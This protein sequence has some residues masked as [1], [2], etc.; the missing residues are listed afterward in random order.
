MRSSFTR[1]RRRGRSVVGRGVSRECSE[2]SPVGCSRSV[3]SG[4]IVSV[5]MFVVSYPPPPHSPPRHHRRLPGRGLTYRIA[6]AHCTP[7]GTMRLVA[8]LIV[9]PTVTQDLPTATSAQVCSS[10]SH[11]SN[12]PIW[13]AHS[14]GAS[15]DVH[16]KR[17]VEMH[18]R[19]PRV[20]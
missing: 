7:G 17:R 9:D 1:L 10:C 13:S 5:S 4:C 12:H 14:S 15:R 20:V 3:N 8:S 16:L 6:N 11:P 18:V 19:K 2:D